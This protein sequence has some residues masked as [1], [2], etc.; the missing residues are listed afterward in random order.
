MK[1]MLLPTAALLIVSL[2]RPASALV[3]LPTNSLESLL[4]NCPDVVIATVVSTD[5]PGDAA[6]IKVEN[7][8]KGDAAGTLTVQKLHLRLSL[9]EKKPR[10]EPKDTVIVFLNTTPDGKHSIAH[11]Q[12]LANE[13]DRKTMEACVKEVLPHA[14]ILSDLANPKIALDEK[15]IK[16]SLIALVVSDNPYTQILLGRLM[17]TTLAE[18]VKPD[19]D[20]LF[21]ALLS[22][23]KELKKGALAWTKKF[24]QLPPKIR[25]LVQDIATDPKAGDLAEE[26]KALLK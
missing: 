6:T 1:N 18:R 11:S 13:A 3:Y 9:K 25:L 22:P 20:V 16:Q 10:F 21:L 4:A 19:P 5:V 2:A 23:R 26:A 15:A 12:T 24:A 14:K 7:A 17:S 8:L